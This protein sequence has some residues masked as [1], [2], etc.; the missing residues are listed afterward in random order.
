MTAHDGRYQSTIAKLR[1]ARLA[2][3]LSQAELGA[4]LNRWQQFVSKYESGE[5]RLDFVELIDISRALSVD[6]KI[7]LE[8]L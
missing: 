1:A 6:Y 2:A 4:Q 7:L 5:R 3:G 8:D